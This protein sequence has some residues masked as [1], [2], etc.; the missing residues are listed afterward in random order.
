M[1]SPQVVKIG[2][3]TVNVAYFVFAEYTEPAR[4]PPADPPSP[5]PAGSGAA[6][7]AKPALA[8]ATL[9]VTFVGGTCYTFYGEDAEDMRSQ[10]DILPPPS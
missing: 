4:R 8:P 1:S 5:N 6:V 3:V 2:N 9:K 7:A 10:L